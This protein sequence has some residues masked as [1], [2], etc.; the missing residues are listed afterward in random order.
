MRRKKFKSI[1]PKDLIFDA[2]GDKYIEAGVEKII[3]S[4][5]LKS[6]KIEI[7]T[8]IKGQSPMRIEPTFIE[9]TTIN[10]VILKK[11]IKIIRNREE[12]EILK[13]YIV[14]DLLG[15]EVDLYY[16]KVNS[17]EFIKFNN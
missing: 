11:L 16:K 5:D 9:A 15:R 1:T 7:D 8:E 14:V 2:L 3:I 4:K 10:N 6:K 13:F 17:K 12:Y